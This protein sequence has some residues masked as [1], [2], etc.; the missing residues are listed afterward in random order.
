MQ[1]GIFSNYYSVRVGAKNYQLGIVTMQVATIRVNAT[2]PPAA[3]GDH[4]DMRFVPGDDDTMTIRMT[5]SA[6]A[7]GSP[8]PLPSSS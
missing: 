2:Q 6:S 4:M 7:I 8:E 5:S 1:Q 3:H